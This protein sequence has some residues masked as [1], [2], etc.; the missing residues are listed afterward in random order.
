[1]NS[2]M[3]DER[4]FQKLQEM[5]I[6]GDIDLEVSR[7]YSSAAFGGPV[8][9]FLFTVVVVAALVLCCYLLYVHQL[10]HALCCFIALLVFWKV[11]SK[12]GF[13]YYYIRSMKHMDF[14][15]KAYQSR[16][17]RL[18]NV[19]TGEYVSYPTSWRSALCDSCIEDER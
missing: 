2:S 1:M 9:G 3:D 16:M 10:L 18:Q 5:I 17:I 7:T 15:I 6:N 19:A 14:F 11:W 12:L 13:Y 4:K 8:G